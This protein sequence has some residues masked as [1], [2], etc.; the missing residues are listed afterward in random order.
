MRKRRNDVFR[1][2]RGKK[3][4]KVWKWN[5]KEIEEVKEWKYL[6]FILK[7]DEGMETQV[8]D[9]VEKAR[10]VMGQ[11]W[12]IGK[13]RFGDDFKRRIWFNRLVG[14]TLGYGAEIWGWKKWGEI[15][16]I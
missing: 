6:G 13:R 7:R 16:K 15:E 4:E 9:R 12:R 11:V 5:G 2:G 1:K 8:R 3:R 10:V 14:S